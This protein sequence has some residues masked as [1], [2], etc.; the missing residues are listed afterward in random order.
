MVT[1]IG[2]HDLKFSA[3]KVKCYQALPTLKW[4]VDSMT[5]R[6]KDFD[7]VKSVF[8]QREIVRSVKKV[9][10]DSALFSIQRES[11]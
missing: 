6:S 5:V 11:M 10:L 2:G 7:C 1:T 4:Y 9:V 3:S 8:D